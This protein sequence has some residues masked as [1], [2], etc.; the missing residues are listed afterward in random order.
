MNRLVIIALLI[1]GLAVS[2]AQEPTRWRGPSG[3]GIYPET[4]LLKQWPA[5]GPEI[6]WTYDQ[7]GQGHASVVVAHDFVYT[8][9]MIEGTGYLF[10]F[11]IKGNLVY[12]KPYGPEF[13]E[14]WYGTRGSPVVVEDKIYLVSGHGKLVCLDNSYGNILWSKELF[15]DFDGQNITWGMNET[16]VVDGDIIYVTPGGRNNNVVA[17]NRHSGKLV[18]SSKGEGELSAYCTPLLFEHNGRKILALH[19]QY[20]LIGLDARTGKMLWSKRQPN[21]WSVHANTPIYHNGALF[22]FSGYGQ[23]GGILKISEDGSSVTE[24]WFKASMDSRMGG[25]VLVDG[26]LYSS[27]DNY[28]EWRCVE[29]ESGKEMYVSD[30]VAKGAVISAE[31]MLYCYSERGELALVKATPSGF[32]LVSKTHV[33]FGSEQHWAHPMIHK[34]VLYVRHGRALIAYDIKK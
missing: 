19:T 28:R 30:T 4:G 29:W 22:Y 32:D 16:P 11:D 8:T 7:L 2:Q 12:K 21:E 15:K 23:G 13:T 3:N 25:A 31:G 5:E 17:L 20:H 1:S 33:A 27:G 10:K 18:W 14:S 26:Y 6:A 24:S 34:G 9:G